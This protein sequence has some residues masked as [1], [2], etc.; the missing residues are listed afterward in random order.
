MPDYDKVDVENSP[1]ASEQSDTYEGEHT[2]FTCLLISNRLALSTPELA[3]CKRIEAETTIGI[4][5]NPRVSRLPLERG[6]GN[7]R[8]P[9]E[10]GYQKIEA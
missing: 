9:G 5:H 1:G 10:G 7:K 8:V 6:E 4:F 2:I 3:S